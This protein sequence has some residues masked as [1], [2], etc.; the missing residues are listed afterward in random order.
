M[1]RQA[2]DGLPMP[3]AYFRLILRRF[4]RTPALVAE[5]LEGT[6]IDLESAGR[7]DIIRVEQQLQ[8]VQNLSRAVG[9]GW[10]LEAGQWFGTA[11]HG[12]QAAATASAP[13]LSTALH[14]I[15]RFAYLRA[16]YFQI[17]STA[18]PPKFDIHITPRMP[19][20]R[21]VWAPLVE[22]LMLSIQAVIESALGGPMDGAEFHFDFD[23]PDYSAIYANTFH[24]PVTFDCQH[25]GISIPASWLPLPCPFS[26][27][28]VHQR[29]I[30]R[31][32]VAER[33]L[34]GPKFIV[35]QIEE[36]LHNSEGVP[37]SVQSIA[38]QLHISRRTLVRR[39]EEH[40][41]SIRS[42]TERHQ[43]RRSIEL[44]ADL[45]LDISEVADKLG[46][47]EPSNFSRAFR[48]W[49][50]ESPQEYRD[51]HLKA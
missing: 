5:I 2:I 50:G 33:N 18:S 15:E 21:E 31:L 23:A 41:T 35:A 43:R 22:A 1:S 39:L 14:L 32:E 7:A 24:A 49:F 27:P 48:R 46:Y 17:F 40:G 36:T 45:N 51:V 10:A 47:S 8:Q 13:D 11:A 20:E 6:G 4:G 9:P 37:P 28:K 30:D 3:A 26:D 16:P 34:Q 25:V 42:L 12:D 29:A 44:L 19:I 38:T